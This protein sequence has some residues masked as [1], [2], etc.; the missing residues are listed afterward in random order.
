[1]V[2]DIKLPESVRLAGDEHTA[3]AF[4]DLILKFTAYLITFSLVAR[5]WMEHLKLFRYLKDYD[6][7]L[8][9]LNLVFLFTVTLFPFAVSLITRKVNTETAES[10]WMLTIYVMVF[11]STVFT[12]SLIARYLL[13]Y[14]DKLCIA[15]TQLENSF[16]WKTTRMNFFLLPVF[17]IAIL[18]FCYFHFAYYFPL[19]SITL[20]GAT[21]SYFKKKY[22]PRE[23]EGPILLRLYRYIKPAKKPVIVKH[24]KVK[25]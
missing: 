25:E 13:K 21:I 9:I 6:R 4:K 11:F 3:E 8:L 17:A 15:T 20:Y 16:E 1:M 24:K 7:K 14:R 10:N 2:L 18:C 5:F 19:Y 12:Q 23:N 22:Y